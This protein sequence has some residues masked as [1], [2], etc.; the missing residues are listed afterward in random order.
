[1]I[2]SVLLFC[3]YP[4]FQDIIRERIALSEKWKMNLPPMGMKQWLPVRYW[5]YRFRTEWGE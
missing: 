5:I 2:S 1:M 3:C 4:S